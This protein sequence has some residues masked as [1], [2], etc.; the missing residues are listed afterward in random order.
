M[1]FF[2]NRLLGF[3]GLLLVSYGHC[4]LPLRSPRVEITDKDTVGYSFADQDK[5]VLE[6]AESLQ[7][8]F[9]KLHEQRTYGGKK[10]SIVHIGDSHILG[11]YMT[12]E[13]R[14]RLQNAFGDAGRGVIF[15][16]RLS[17]SNGPEDYLVSTNSRWKGANC[18]RERSQVEFGLTGFRIQPQSA[19]ASLN[20]QLRD[21]TA[22]NQAR[23]FTKITVYHH[24]SQPDFDIRDEAGDQQA[25][26]ILTNDYASSYYFDH[27]ASQFS[28]QNRRPDKDFCVDGICLEN[29]LS[30]IVYNSIGVNGAHFTDF[31]RAQFFARQVGE[32][33]PDLIILSFGTN[34]AQDPILT[35]DALYQQIEKL[36]TLL[37]LDAPG[38]KFLLTTPADSYWRSGRSFN[39]NMARV[40][41]TI[42]RFAEEHDMAVWDLFNITGGENSAVEWKRRGLMSR[43][44]VHYSKLGYAMQGKLFYQSIIKGYNQRAGVNAE[45]AH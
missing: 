17:G 29:E 26:L 2:S 25:N 28:L 18:Q 34:E 14:T 27:P 39:P 7:P 12:R 37:A 40:A 41:A 6:N 4:Q 10:I 35:E 23:L 43:D 31:S 21:T 24:G 9:E 13:V 33:F 44:S 45:V 5:N 3:F 42:R 32:L 30:G 15:P 20:F 8:F 38:A 11:N 1:P 22:E 16:Y 19:N 36:T